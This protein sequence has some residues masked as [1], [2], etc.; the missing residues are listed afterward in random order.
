MTGRNLYKNPVQNDLHQ[1]L[2]RLTWFLVQIILEQVCCTEQNTA[3]IGW[4]FA[5]NQPLSG[6]GV[7][8]E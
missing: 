1:K 4:L 6:H 8:S 2:A 5:L 7:L 3:L